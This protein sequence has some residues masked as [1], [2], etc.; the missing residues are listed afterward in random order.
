MGGTVGDAASKAVH[1]SR[2]V[3][4][5]SYCKG[6]KAWCGHG[7]MSQRLR[8]LAALSE[9]LGSIPSTHTVAHGCLYPQFQGYTTLSWPLW[10]PDIQMVHTQKQAKYHYEQNARKGKTENKS[11]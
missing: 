1:T 9:D 5:N 10:T 6:S 2:E 8:E 7:E 3:F 11:S 4:P